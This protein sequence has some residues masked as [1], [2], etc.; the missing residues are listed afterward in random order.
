[1]TAAVHLVG[2][3]A[4]PRVPEVFKTVGA[5]LG[6]S[7]RRVPDG[8][9]GGRR[10]WISW[11]YPLLR[12]STYLEPAEGAEMR[13]SAGFAKLQLKKGVSRDELSFG[14]LGYAR[15][16]RPSYEDFLRARERGEI[17]PEARFQVCL[18]TPFA[19]VVAFCAP[20]AVADIEPAYERAMLRE[21]EDICAAIPHK[22]LCLQWDVCVEMVIWD[23]Q[24]KYHG[25]YQANE[26][27]MLERLK[28][29]SAAVPASV[30]LGYHLCYGDWDAKH[31]VEPKD[32]ARM[33]ALANALSDT[34]P[35]DIAYI[36][37]PVPI[38]RTDDAF[39]APFDGLRLKKGTELYLGLV[40]ADGIDG[41]IKRAE[42]ALKHLSGFGIAAECGL[43]RCKTPDDVRALLDTHAAAA[44]K[45]ADL[46]SGARQS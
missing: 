26:A 41:T 45:I 20:D 1:M 17:H 39:F 33:V 16:A 32:A 27:A 2:S 8:E 5:V 14:E 37:M 36:H 24:I 4:L 19:V 11:Q 29:I 22:D 18:P 31:F 6:P 13:A 40:N 10:C 9:P 28:R 15:E 43:G 44:A 7:V 12:A 46:A 25:M 21:V 30:E 23:G 42:A 3:I 38:A 34:V 35:H